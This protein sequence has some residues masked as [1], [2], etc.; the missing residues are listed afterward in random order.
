MR[1]LE[2]VVMAE[3]NHVVIAGFRHRPRQI[4]EVVH[5]ES[6]AFEIRLE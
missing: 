2:F 4:V 5:R 6:L 3:A 1:N